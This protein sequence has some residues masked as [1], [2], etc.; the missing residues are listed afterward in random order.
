VAQDVD[1][2]VRRTPSP[3]LRNCP[4]DTPTQLLFE[5]SPDLRVDPLP[6]C[7]V[8]WDRADVIHEVS[9]TKV[10]VPFVGDGFEQLFAG[11]AA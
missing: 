7:L 5:L 11:L 9:G 10:A 6:R 2:P 3:R 4:L 1:A 8:Y